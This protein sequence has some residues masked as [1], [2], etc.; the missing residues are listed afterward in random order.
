MSLTLGAGG[1]LLIV[2]TLAWLLGGLPSSVFWL[3]MAAFTVVLV[4]IGLFAWQWPA[5]H[6]RHLFYRVDRQGLGI[7]RGVIW[8]KVISIPTTRVQHID[9]TQGPLQR[10][11]GLATLTIHTAGTQG[12]SIPLSG[13][14][15]HTATELRDHLLPNSR[16]GQ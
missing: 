6:Y 13:L 8:R 1:I 2:S 5:V 12:A 16:H 15:H 10:V 3:L 7:R 14:A 9:V 4:A 11:H